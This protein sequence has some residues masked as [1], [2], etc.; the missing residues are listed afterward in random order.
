M[1]VKT[2]IKYVEYNWPDID[3]DIIK[4]PLALVLFARLP[5]SKLG[6]LSVANIFFPLKKIYLYSTKSIIID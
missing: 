2:K 6:T 4:I 3:Y 5:I 1:R